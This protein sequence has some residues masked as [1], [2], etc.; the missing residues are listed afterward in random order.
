MR[1]AVTS[2]QYT[3][4][5]HWRLLPIAAKQSLTSPMQSLLSAKRCSIGG[6]GY[7]SCKPPPPPTP[8][9][10][11]PAFSD[12]YVPWRVSCYSQIDVAHKPP[13]LRLNLSFHCYI[14]GRFVVPG[15]LHQ[16]A[17]SLASLRVYVTDYL[18]GISRNQMPT[19]GLLNACNRRYH[20]T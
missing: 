17:P 4:G 10:P 15:F 19:S 9:T 6:V 3:S 12:H 14:I 5:L 13:T 18:V 11:H 8:Y 1:T 16:P 2:F 20:S 7:E